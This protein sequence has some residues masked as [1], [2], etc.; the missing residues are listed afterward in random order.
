M[1]MKKMMMNDEVGMAVV[2]DDDWTLFVR[3]YILDLNGKD[4]IFLNVED[5]FNR[6]IFF[7]SI[8]VF[9]FSITFDI[10]IYIRTCVFSWNKST[11][12][13]Y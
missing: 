8:I 11:I 1:M 12:F 5:P 3:G 9:K 10:I 13:I 4:D 7:F 2:I 6:F